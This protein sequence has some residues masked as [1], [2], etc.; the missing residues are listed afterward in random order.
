[1]NVLLIE[2][3]ADDA[4]LLELAL[5]EL[6]RPLRMRRVDDATSLE[7]ALDDPW[8]VVIADY[9][10]PA[11]DAEQALAILNFR[12]CAA[13]F[14]VVSGCIGEETTVRLLKQG[15]ADCVMKDHLARLAPAVRR[16]LNEAENRRAR[17]DAEA[18]LERL[19]FFDE[20]TGLPNRRCFRALLAEALE[21]DGH[22]DVLCLH[23]DRLRMIADTL[24]ERVSETLL[25]AIAERLQKHL[26]DG[27][28]G[29]L[30]GHIGSAEFGIAAH[31]P[32]C[33]GIVHRVRDLLRLPFLV[34]Q[35][36]LFVDP[37]IG[38]GHAPDDGRDA[39]VL[40]RNAQAAVQRARTLGQ[41]VAGYT[42]EIESEALRRLHVGNRLHGVAERGDLHLLYQPKIALQDGSVCGLEALLRWDDP[43][44]G[45]VSPVCFVPVAEETGEIVPIGAW[46]IHEVCRQLR[47][48]IDD[49]L[50]P[51]PVAVNVAARQ[52]RDPGF[53]Q[54]I[55]QALAMYRLTPALLALEITESDVMADTATAVAILSAI[56]AMGI[57]IAVD[58]FGTGY[59]SLGY[60]RRLPISHIKIDRSFI[61]HLPGD[62]E[63]RAI[64]EAIVALAR[65]LR[66][67]VVAE[68]VEN[69]EQA[70]FLLGQGCEQAQGFLF[71]RPLD[72]RRVTTFLRETAFGEVLPG[73]LSVPALSG[74]GQVDWMGDSR[75]G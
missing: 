32:Q 30:V 36:E 75:T 50:E 52:L 42:P 58:D 24:G 48:W 35:R 9:A 7:T 8:D 57:A 46:V 6:D 21:G 26:I 66:L 71:A 56:R 13:P 16:E 19:A 63:D 34:G 41:V 44:L 27:V 61:R 5:T 38:I 20:V 17:A 47:T 70:Q 11:F 39:E 45:P 62:T 68:G 1:L 15:V 67:T 12:R 53:V 33:D 4:E 25:R 54:V 2:D 60:L 29:V 43:E 59:S 22:V 51:L 40:V 49:G 31:R 74:Q 65:A 3:S 23:I 28:E 55:E 69:R 72:H 73:I 64:V 14:I 18:E 37:V 10:L